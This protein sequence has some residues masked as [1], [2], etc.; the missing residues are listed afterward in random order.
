MT[1]LAYNEPQWAGLA[2]GN[3]IGDRS[4]KAQYRTAIW[5][6]RRKARIAF[7]RSFMSF[8]DDQI[9]MRGISRRELAARCALGLGTITQH[10]KH[11][12]KV[13]VAYFP[14][15]LYGVGIRLEF[16]AQPVQFLEEIPNIE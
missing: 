3:P 15:Y 6:Q 11:P 8:I 16:K 2:A 14:I 7:S 13:H 5:T 4:L 12:E 1:K 10:F 9:R